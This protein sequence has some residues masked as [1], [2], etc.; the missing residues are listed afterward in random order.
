MD[1][2]AAHPGALNTLSQNMGIKNIPGKK[3]KEGENYAHIVHI[4][5]MG[6]KQHHDPEV[7]TCLH[8]D[9]LASVVGSKEA[10]T[11]AM[12]YSYKHGFSGF[13]A[14]FTESQVKKIADFPGV[15]RVI[16][17]QFHSLQ[18]TRSWDYLGLSPNSPNNLLKDTNLGDGI[19]IGL[20]DT[21]LETLIR[22][23]SLQMVT[24][25]WPESEV[26]N[27]EDLGP[28]PSQWK[29][30][31]VS[32]KQFNAS[33]AC[34]KI[35]LMDS[36]DF[37]SPRDVVGHGTHTSTIA[38]GSFVYNA[39]YKGIGLGIVRGGAPRA[40][41]AMYKVC[42]NVPRGQ[43]SN[44]DLLKA[45]DDA[46]HDGVDV[47]SVSLGTQLPLFSEVDDRDAISIGSFHAV[48]KGIPVVCGAANEGPS[49]YTVENTAP[50]IL[51]VAASTIDRSFPTNITL[52]NNLTILGQA[53]F[54]GTEV[55]FTG[56]VYPENP[57]LIPS[58]AG[59]CEALLLNNTPVAG[60]V[61]LCF[62][63]VARRTPVALAVSS[64]KA[65]GGVGVI[66]A[67]SPGDVLGPCSSDFPCIEVD[68]ELGTQ[69]LL[70]I[71]STSSP[72]V[73]LNPSMTLVGKPVSTKVAAFSS[74]GPNSISPAILKPDIAAPGVSILAASA[75]FD[76]YMNGGFA[77]HSGTSMA[78]PHVSGV[79]AH[80]KAL[81]SSW[82]PAAIRSAIVTT[83]WRTDPF[84]EPIFAEGSPQKLADPFDYGGGIVNPNKA[85]DPGLVYDLVVNDYILYLCAVGY[86]NSEISQ[87]VGHST[88]CSSTKPSVLD[89]N[90]PSI[91]VPNLREN[92]TLTRSVTNVGPV[93]STYKARIS[94]PWGIS[95]AV[96]PETLV[97]NSN[98]ETISFTVEVSTIHEVNT[99]T[100]SAASLGL[101]N[102]GI[103][104][105][106]AGKNYSLVVLVLILIQ[107]HLYIVVDATC[108][109]CKAFDKRTF[110][111]HIVYL[112]E[113]KHEDPEFT[114]N[115]HHKMLTNLLGSKEAAY[116]SILYSYKHGFSGFA[117]RLTESQVETIAEFPGVLQVIPN[118]VHKLQTTRSWDFIENHQHSPENHLRRSMGKGTII[119]VIDSGVWPE[120]ESYNDEGMDPIPSH[121]KGICQL[122]ELFNSTNCNKKLIGALWF[123]KGALDEFKTLDKTDRVDFLSPRDGIGHGTHTASTAAGYF[124]KRTNYRGLASGLARG[125]APLAHLAIYKVCW[126]NRGCTDADLLKAFDKAIHDGVD[127]L[128]LSVGNDVP[129]F[130]YV[131]LRDTIAIGDY[132]LT[133]VCSAGND[134]PISQ[135]IVN[136][137]PWLITVAATKIDRAFPAAIT[138]GNNQT[139]WGQ[140]IDIGKHNHGFSGLTYSER[141]AIDSTDESAKDCQ[142]GRLNA[143]LA[144]G[145]IVLCFS[146]SDEQ[147]I[148]SASATVKKAG[149][150]GLI[151][152]EFPNDGLES[153]K[154]P[155]IKVDYTVGTQILLYIRKAR[156]PIGKLS[157]PITVVGKWVS[158]QVATFSSRGPSSMTPTVLK[159][160]IAAPGVDILAAFR[161]HEKKQSNGYA[162]RSGTSMACPH[163]T[164]IV[165]L[166]KSVHQDWSPAAIKSALVTTGKSNQTLY[167]TS[168]TEIHPHLT[169]TDHSTSTSMQIAASQ[170]GTD[171]TS[172]SAQGQTRKEADPFDIGGGHVD[173][174][175]AMDPGLIYNATTNDYIQFLC[176]LGYSTASLTR[177]TN[178]TI[179][180]ITNPHARNLNLP[181]ITIPNLKRTST[182]T[183]T[184]T[185]V[186][187]I[188]S[189]YRVMVQAPPGVEMTVKPQTLSFNITTQILSYK[190]TFFSTQKVNGGYKFGSLTWTDG[191]HDVRIPIAI[192]VTA[193]ESYAHVQIS[194]RVFRSDFR[195]FSI[196]PAHATPF[197]FP[198]VILDL[199]RWCW[200]EEEGRRDRDQRST[201]IGRE[202]L[203]E[204]AAQI[205]DR[206]LSGLLLHS[207]TVGRGLRSRR[208]EETALPVLE[209]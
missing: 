107:H 75:P 33:T 124:V 186:G 62:T 102:W 127:I 61:V 35:T 185:N 77:L 58:L 82:S 170:T 79:V 52:G 20:L 151:Y 135:T 93:N 51:T 34:N 6:E 104:G 91:T 101:M 39:S 203:S 117:A 1:G 56:L 10:A 155:C 2:C 18:T 146:T 134:G 43:C 47:I 28:I 168:K 173:P 116:N 15:I 44:A 164:G 179:N 41:L 16:P 195:R 113:K 122:G 98:I 88:T 175:K 166:I 26:F 157:D 176:S 145:K 66:V 67:K 68:Y 55:D 96:S 137:A 9:M 120:S 188:D 38:G 159:P 3:K 156:Y 29:G 105:T 148:V 103:N 138:L 50:W 207:N 73:K 128:S 31:C 100:T 131:D 99:G 22:Q 189:K 19:I 72:V 126:T 194:G 23:R 60:N 177:L 76:P 74:R 64:V 114:K 150:I 71:R 48:T 84:G 109:D 130:S 125:G 147:D 90:L 37:M 191:E 83:A 139:L 184:V 21:V 108:K 162:L 110:Q 152:A 32:G 119:G 17:N 86:N 59:V 199:P 5:Y 7:V 81:H 196:I 69:I 53:L 11:D 169:Y 171:G 133:V 202:A 208:G 8:H 118:R 132:R 136:T 197:F 209:W 123:V 190:V 181:S 204:I 106:C 142:S 85:A 80:L 42:W 144:S 187:K 54:A 12:V 57:G 174:N 87:L 40:R 193:F 63:S 121:W 158:P 198:S 200:N 94:P 161:P 89:V 115:F 182:V 163:V 178:T 65:A 95:V 183:R 27:D 45:F 167:F 129:L 112:G 49:A 160:D 165:A 70:Y 78:T 149:G 205:S 25:I 141:I 140:S 24:G 180:C 14:K 206:D 97:F 46:I 4:V 111:V 143:T 36:P 201:M 13:A 92:I 153:C 30:Q 192:R 172:I 154:I